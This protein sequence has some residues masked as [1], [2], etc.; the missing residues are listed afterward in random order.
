MPCYES[1][2]V[3]E[4]ERTTAKEFVIVLSMGKCT[5]RKPVQPETSK[6]HVGMGFIL[7]V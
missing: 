2:L 5:T 4:N 7:I 3:G 6:E 1:R